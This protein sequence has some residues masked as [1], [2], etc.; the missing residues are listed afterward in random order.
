LQS[1]QLD[2]ASHRF[3][4]FVVLMLL[5]LASLFSSTRAAA[6]ARRMTMTAHD[7]PRALQPNNGSANN[8]EDVGTSDGQSVPDLQQGRA[9]LQE[10]HHPHHGRRDHLQQPVVV[11]VRP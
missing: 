7:N 8:P 1:S 9:A 3:A 5:I 6:A 11:R 10:I 4:K 2:N